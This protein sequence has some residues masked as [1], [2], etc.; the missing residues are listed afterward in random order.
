MLKVV[1]WLT[2]KIVSAVI[3]AHQ[4]KTLPNHQ[5][6]CLMN[7]RMT[8]KKIVLIVLCLYIKKCILFLLTQIKI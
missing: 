1:N 3:A 8:Y 4:V 6:F 7:I 5:R 2:K